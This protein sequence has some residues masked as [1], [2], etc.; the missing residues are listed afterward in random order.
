VCSYLPLHVQINT[1]LF[2]S[3]FIHQLWI[4]QP[5]RTQLLCTALNKLRKLSIHGMYIEFDLLW[6]INLLEAAPTVE[7]FD[8]EV[9]YSF[10]SQFLVGHFLVVDTIS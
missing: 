6:T 4:L 8:I 2:N 5:E 3:L 9:L 7:I 10:H 1:S